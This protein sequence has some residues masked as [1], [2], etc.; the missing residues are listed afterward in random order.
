MQAAP[1]GLACRA[2]RARSHADMQYLFVNGRVVRDRLLA[3]AVRLGL[4]RRA[5][6]RRASRH[7]CC[8]SSSIRA[9]VDVNVHPAKLEVRFRDSRLVHDFVYRTVETALASTLSSGERDAPPPVLGTAFAA[10]A[11]LG[12][13][14]GASAARAPA[15]RGA[16]AGVALSS[17]SRACRGDSAC[18]GRSTS[19]RS[20]T[21]SR[22]SR[23]STS[24][25]QNR[26]RPDRRRHA[27]GARAHHLRAAEA[28]PRDASAD[29]SPAGAGRPSPSAPRS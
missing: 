29:R 3:H 18:G 12:L 15:E 22:S 9:R 28:R 19:R 2:R 5:V 14:L 20:A 26:A 17:P 16:R 6:P 25:R 27:R 1:R 10:S 23:A 8:S 24:S 11:R 4:R 7:S 13:Q 21:P